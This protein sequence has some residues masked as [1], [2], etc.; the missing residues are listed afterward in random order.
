MNRISK[1]E[2]TIDSYKITLIP[3]SEQD[4]HS[5]Y[6]L[7]TNSNIRKYLFDDIVIS[8]AEVKNIITKSIELFSSKK[9]GLWLIE[10]HEKHMPVGFAG[11]WH[12]FDEPE[13]QLVAAIHPDDQRLGHATNAIHSLIDYALNFLAFPSV[14]AVCDTG[15]TASLRLFQRVGMRYIGD[16][17]INGK[18]LKYSR[19]EYLDQFIL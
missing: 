7:V 16:K 14:I 4:H 10:S 3:V 11:L 8:E 15:N 18:T 5:L 19:S 17:I 1:K 12:F 2:H 13:P 6:Q 9:Y